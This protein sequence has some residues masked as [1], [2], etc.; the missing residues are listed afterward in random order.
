MVG[1]VAR[2]RGL[3]KVR[4][5]RADGPSRHAPAHEPRQ[6]TA[7]VGPRAPP[8]AVRCGRGACGPRPLG[9]QLLG[10]EG[11]LQERRQEARDVQGHRVPDRRVRPDLFLR[12]PG[13]DRSSVRPRS[14]GARPGHRRRPAGRLPGRREASPRSPRLPARLRPV[15]L[16]QPELARRLPLARLLR[17]RPDERRL[18]ERHRLQHAQG[19]QDRLRRSRRDRRATGATRDRRRA[20]E[21]RGLHA[22]ALGRAA[23]PPRRRSATAWASTKN[24]VLSHNFTHHF[25]IADDFVGAHARAARK[26]LARYIAGLDALSLSQYMDLTTGLPAAGPRPPPPPPTRSRKRSSPTRRSSATRSWAPPSDSNQ[27]R[28]RPCTSASSASGAGASSTRTSGPATPRP[29]RRRSSRARSRAGMK[30]SCA[31]WRS[32]RDAPSR[33]PSS[34]SPAPT[35]TSSAGRTPSTATPRPRRRSRARCTPRRRRSSSASS[36]RARPFRRYRRA[37]KRSASA[38][39]A[40]PRPHLRAAVRTCSKQKSLDAFGAQAPLSCVA[41]GYP[42]TSS[43]SNTSAP[44]GGAPPSVVVPDRI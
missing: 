40:F 10:L 14:R 20:D 16:R 35:T 30:A 11:R 33:A 44:A 18:Q 27:R 28:S 2:G 7:R 17:R 37:R 12:R 25:E 23:A 19:A 6:V 32:P 4:R 36:S 26:A 39:I 5:L 1:F 34:G 38:R 24:V 21:R 8:P 29:R 42:F 15:P 22:R 3:F 13:Q 43:I 31:T 41:K 9:G